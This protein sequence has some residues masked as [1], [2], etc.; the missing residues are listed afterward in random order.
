MTAGDKVEVVA[1]PSDLNVIAEYPIAT[2]KGAPQP[3]LAEAFVELVL[4]P[5]GQKRLVAAGFLGA[6]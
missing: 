2:L 1:I 3:K 6:K 5:E 4:S